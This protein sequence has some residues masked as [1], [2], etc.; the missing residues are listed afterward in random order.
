M[1]GIGASISYIS[2]AKNH[3]R[4]WVWNRLSERSD[5][6]AKERVVLFLAS[7]ELRDVEEALRRGYRRSNLIAIESDRERCIELR[8]KR[9]TTLNLPAGKVLQQWP[10][11]IPVDAVLLDLCGGV[12]GEVNRCLCGLMRSPFAR[13]AVAIN[14]Q[15]GRDRVGEMR[16]EMVAAASSLKEQMLA[17]GSSSDAVALINSVR[18]SYGT[19]SRGFWIKHLRRE[20]EKRLLTLALI[21]FGYD[22]PARQASVDVERLS[23]QRESSIAELSY[24]HRRVVMDTLCFKNSIHGT[25]ADFLD[26]SIE[27]DTPVRRRIAA[28]LAVSTMRREGR[29][30]CH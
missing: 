18:D 10:P 27:A 15:R 30:P 26:G 28:A 11:Y 7:P 5:V 21:H 25:L 12:D 6:P 19:T 4:R 9:I 22:S 17:N 20:L 29:L 13:T 8:A 23:F 3:W 16:E 14:V 2:G 1:S 24:R